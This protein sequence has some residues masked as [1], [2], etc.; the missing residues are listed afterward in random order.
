MPKRG[1][2]G[3]GG[4]SLHKQVD[5]RLTSLVR[6]GQSRNDAKIDRKAGEGIYSRGTLETYRKQ[7]VRF[8]DWCKQE[9]GSKTLDDCR[10]HISA[11]LEHAREECW[12]A[13]SVKTVTSAL[14][15]TYGVKGSYLLNEYGLSYF[16]DKGV[17]YTKD[18]FQRNR[19]DITR[20]RNYQ[21]ERIDVE[22]NKDVIDFARG[23]GL[24]RQ[25]LENVRPEWVSRTQDGA[26]HIRL[27][28]AEESKYSNGTI[29]D[30]HTKGGRGRTLEVLPEYA[31][32]VWSMTR[33]AKE[34]DTI[35]GNVVGHMDVH[36]Y[37]A[38]YAN[39][40]YRQYARDIG[41]IQDDRYIMRGTS[42]VAV[43]KASEGAPWIAD[44]EHG[45]RDVPA[46]YKCIGG[47]FSGIQLDRDAMV[48]VA[49]NLGHNR[50]SI[51]ALN[52]LRK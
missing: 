21:I 26:V 30:A 4:P 10:F 1:S 39:A 27:P 34:G 19:D 15:K 41:S 31:D 18:L 16:P 36:S 29:P 51:F 44:K 14:A 8:T 17:E 2:R 33:A 35:I 23:T 20:S 9:Y 50:E 24:R 37:R 22:A 52:Y 40:I 46:V 25:E 43:Y 6:F 3:R 49:Q 12:S 11:Y 45:E 28:S 13:H 7:A 47:Q 32:H 5:D 38:E 42:V 48:K